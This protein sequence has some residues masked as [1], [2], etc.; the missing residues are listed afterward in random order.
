MGPVNEM[1]DDL[2]ISIRRICREK[3]VSISQMEADLG[4]SPGLISRWNKTK[5]SPSFDKIV[6]IVDYLDI[7]FD[8]LMSG[9]IQEQSTNTTFIHRK[10]REICEKLLKK[11]ESGQMKWF[12]LSKDAPFHVTF[13]DVFSEW[14]EYRFHV[15]YYTSFG[16]GFFIMALQYHDISLDMKVDLFSLAE[17]GFDLKHIHDTDSNAKRILKYVNKELYMKLTG[18]K[19]KSMEDEFLA[20]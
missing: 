6:A 11:S 17:V 2:V 19:T 18:Q 20:S 8:E 1:I 16:A 10:E 3:N 7:T 4:F 14:Q 13:E 15:V 12:E 5:T 9:D